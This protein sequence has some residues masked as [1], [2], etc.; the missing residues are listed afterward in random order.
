MLSFKPHF[1]CVLRIKSFS[2]YLKTIQVPTVTN[3]DRIITANYF[4]RMDFEFVGIFQKFMSKATSY[5]RILLN[6]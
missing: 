6:T 2:E 5:L 1:M 3:F 4:R